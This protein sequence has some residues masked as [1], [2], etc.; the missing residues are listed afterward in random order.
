M[1]T[2]IGL[3]EV[4]AQFLKQRQLS[5]PDGRPLYSYQAT[6]SELSLLGQMLQEAFSE[7]ASSIWASPAAAGAFCLWAAEWWR[8]HHS[9]GAWK[10]EGILERLGAES[11]N[12]GK[13]DYHLL[14]HIVELGLQEFWRVE[15][16][17]TGVGRGFLVTLACQGGLPLQ[18]VRDGRGVGR[19][20]R[21]FRA[22]L[23]ELALP[24][25][26]RV[27]PR[28]I[29][30]RV[31]DALPRSL[32][33]EVVYELAG[34]LASEIR[35]L[36]KMLEG[37][38][39]NGADPVELLDR[40]A[41]DWRDKLPLRL[42]DEVAHA[43]LQNLLD[44]ATDIASRSAQRIQWSRRLRREG[45]SWLLE[46]SAQLPRRLDVAALRSRFELPKETEPPR[47]A[48][49]LHL[50]GTEVGDLAAGRPQGTSTSG[51]QIYSVKPRSFGLV[52]VKGGQAVQEATLVLSG[53]G[54]RT[55]SR[56][57]PLEGGA[58]LSE[59]PW[60]F[61]G[62]HPE[63]GV[64][65]DLEAEFR[66]EGTLSLGESVV[67]VA[68]LEDSYLKLE[69]G[70]AHQVGRIHGL[71]RDLWQ[72][73][74]CVEFISPDGEGSR[75]ET[76]ADD[77]QPAAEYVVEGEHDG[78][79][80][81]EDPLF[82]SLRFVRYD[83]LGRHE[84][85]PTDHLE[86]KAASSTA[87]WD[88]WV[89]SEH[90]GDG[91]LRVREGGRI[92]AVRRVRLLPQ[93]A[94]VRLKPL[95][96]RTSAG[97]I[98]L[99]KFGVPDGLTITL[100]SPGV[101]SRAES[102]TRV[103]Q[104]LV[105]SVETETLEERAVV[106]LDWTTGQRLRLYLPFPGR[107]FSF[108]G[109]GGRVLAEGDQLPMTRLS[110]VR[111]MAFIDSR[112]PKPVLTWRY[113]G[114]DRPPNSRRG[115]Q[116]GRRLVRDAYVMDLFR[117]DLSALGL[118]DWTRHRLDASRDPQARI[119]LHIRDEN[120]SNRAGRRVTLGRF[121]LRV[122]ADEETGAV[123][124]ERFSGDEL[125]IEELER[126]EVSALELHALYQG[127]SED[128]IVHEQILPRL[129]GERMRWKLPEAFGMSLEEFLIVAREGYLHRAK[130]LLWRPLT[131]EVGGID[132]DEVHAESVK[133]AA[134]DP[135]DDQWSQIDALIRKAGELPASSF[136]LLRALAESP[137]GLALA[138]LITPALREEEVWD[139]LQELGFLWLGIPLAS[140]SAAIQ[141][142][143]SEVK[144]GRIQAEHFQAGV[145]ELR[146]RLP[147]LKGL[148]D[149]T[150]KQ[151][152]A[153]LEGGHAIIPPPAW[154]AAD[155][156]RRAV[157]HGWKSAREL[158]A[159]TQHGIPTPTGLPSLLD[160][161]EKET[162]T[163]GLAYGI[164]KPDYPKDDPKY[165]IMNAPVLLAAATVFGIP[166]TGT[167][168]LTFRV[169]RGKNTEWFDATWGAALNAM[170][171]T[172]WR[173]GHDPS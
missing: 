149:R 171:M 75:V 69:H 63:S 156:F 140:W 151:T 48:L 123:R 17:M 108:V 84:T 134:T 107:W 155:E 23:N 172:Q 1:T 95:E 32:R 14:T 20:R 56:G 36:Q 133:R 120:D 58:P 91:W 35:V 152:V 168:S 145:D 139:D 128:V 31:S 109:A 83:A 9:G 129:D 12:P 115:Y 113:L 173:H 62:F 27:E 70:E 39:S 112:A 119:E 29:A 121:D 169:V 165:L 50:D 19:I 89:E 97:E 118:Y 124:V 131:P 59:L 52:S 49:K 90:F 85:I 170:L 40:H 164:L 137:D 41:G 4:I 33:Q 66:G 67:L 53:P 94:K 132:L 18:L 57:V 65:E 72:V 30:R 13:P 82:R 143:L 166:L 105:L 160:K 114:A 158:V 3:E 116:G 162:K 100:E 144:T 101:L 122:V 92:R 71:P 159:E 28:R 8:E 22:L 11:L 64:G 74:G 135:L 6:Q 102:A 111:A 96:G 157:Q 141:C 54:L 60:I 47:F 5:A 61:A 163:G 125:P 26:E 10:W 150:I 146:D 167:D 15:L 78:V 161:V 44:E 138:A 42:D 126:L 106:R 43:L 93:G 37:H 77:G 148:L 86:W 117:L 87:H 80:L 103:G 46:A 147:G 73:R 130:P 7:D 79:D 2:V 142:A 34:R 16:L 24:G 127:P 68:A 21:F 99:A 154:D 45:D 88:P 81:G 76:G 104:V 136:P 153:K 110:G 25:A 38:G 51:G 98:Y 55:A